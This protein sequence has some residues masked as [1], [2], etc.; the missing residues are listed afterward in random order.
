MLD[1][2]QYRQDLQE[3]RA[4][5]GDVGKALDIP[6]LRDEYAELQEDMSSDGFWDDLERAQKVNRKAHA[7]HANLS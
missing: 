6:R 4:K 1:L 5:I 3:I 7:A 2:E